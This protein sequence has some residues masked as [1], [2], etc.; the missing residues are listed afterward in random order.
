MKDGFAVRRGGD[1]G[2]KETRAGLVKRGL[3]GKEREE[4]CEET[5]QRVGLALHSLQKH[6]VFQDSKKT[7]EVMRPMKSLQ[8]EEHFRA[9]LVHLIL[10]SMMNAAPYG[11]KMPP[12]R[13][14]III[15]EAAG[16]THA[17]EGESDGHVFPHNCLFLSP[18]E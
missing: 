3:I 16:N 5:Q 12:R 8:Y 18:S 15:I 11:H 10:K 4:R 9:S 1:R 6:F 7:Y 2:E 17:R 13:R 14:I